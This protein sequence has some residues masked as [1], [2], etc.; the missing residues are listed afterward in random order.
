MIT[1][2]DHG[3]SV[4]CQKVRLAFA[5][6]A[7]SYVRKN[8]ALEAGEQVEDWFLAVNPKGVVPVLVHDGKTITDSTTILE[9]IDE[10]FPDPPLMPTDPYLRFRRRWWARW[11]DDEMH[12]PH[13]ATISFV[14]AFNA[15]FRRNL[16][17]EEKLAA[18]LDSIPTVSNR[19]AL[20]VS[21]ASDL[22]STAFLTALK[23]YDVFL[24]EMDRSLAGQ[25][26]L[27]G[28]EFS[29]ADIDVFPYIW[30]LHNLQLSE[31]W[32]DRPRVQA[33]LD[34]MTLR[35]S[36][37][38]AIVGM[39]LPEWIELMKATGHQAWPAVARHIQEFRAGS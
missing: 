36:F 38:D 22:Q 1:L 32:A 13:I 24:E 17:T 31:L 21:F 35:P 15:A 3:E 30:R 29:L 34:R 23:A 7:I 27:A 37:Q 19:D 28:P 18:Y 11:I 5:E 8:V 26:W 4:C 9:Y 20:R 10:S 25:Q 6:K 2:Y 14:I 39:Q 16:D 12:V 33:W